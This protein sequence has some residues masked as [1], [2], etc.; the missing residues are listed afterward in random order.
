M[1][2]QH[3]FV[4]NF[5]LANPYYFYQKISYLSIE[6]ITMIVLCNVGNFY[7]KKFL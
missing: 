7:Y 1:A 3:K 5:T 2:E 6:S 4:D